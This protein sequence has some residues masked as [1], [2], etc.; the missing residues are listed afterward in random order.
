MVSTRERQACDF[1]KFYQTAMDTFIS[2]VSISV[3]FDCQLYIYDLDQGV[4]NTQR[5]TGTPEVFGNAVMELFAR[6]GDKS[7]HCMG[8][9]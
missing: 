4:L 9:S 7:G 1:K 6:W 5:V 2:K 8:V 3:S